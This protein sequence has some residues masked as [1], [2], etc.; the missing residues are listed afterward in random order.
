MFSQIASPDWTPPLP[1]LRWAGGKRWLKYYYADLFPSKVDRYVEPFL[2]S[3]AVF[4]GI[5]A[6]S[7]VLSD[8]NID[9]IDAYRAIK[10]DWQSVVSQLAK[11]ARKHSEDYYYA[12]RASI[13]RL[14]TNRAARFIYLNRTCFNGIYR[15]NQRGKFNVPIGTRS[16]VL[17]DTDDFERVSKHLQSAELIASD[18]QSILQATFPGDF[19]FVDPPYTVAHNTNGFLKYNEKIFSWDDQIRLHSSLQE[20]SGRGVDFILTN[21]DHPSIANLY[22]HDFCINRVSRNSNIGSLVEC[23]NRITELIIRPKK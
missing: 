22:S 11:H 2:G 16:S 4:F 19:V 13:P 15:V 17:L 10:E 12:Q 20:L 9:L 7:A 23:R 3:G 6:S 8:T 14:L 21:A 18:F 1:F 5:E